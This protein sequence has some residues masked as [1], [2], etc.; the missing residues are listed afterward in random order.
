MKLSGLLWKK[1]HEMF[2]LNN[3]K[4]LQRVGFDLLR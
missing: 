4:E 1:G 2:T 3:Q